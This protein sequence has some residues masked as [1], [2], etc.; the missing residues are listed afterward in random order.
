MGANLSRCMCVYILVK[1]EWTHLR[2]LWWLLN[3]TVEKINRCKLKVFLY[4]S[5]RFENILI[6][7]FGWYENTLMWLLS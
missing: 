2:E 4:I 1:E 3:P 6:W 5:K 7:L